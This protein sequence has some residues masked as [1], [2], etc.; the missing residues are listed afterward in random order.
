MARPVDVV[1]F[2]GG[3]AGLSAALLP[4]YEGKQV[5]LL[6]AGK[7]AGRRGRHNPSDL[8]SGLG[9]AGL[10]SDGK[11]SFFPSASALWR[12]DDR[13]A[14]HDAY[15]W[16]VRVLSD[17][18]HAPKFPSE[19]DI[20]LAGDFVGDEKTYESAYIDFQARL[21]LIERLTKN[22]AGALIRGAQ[23]LSVTETNT[24]LRVRYMRGRR[25]KSVVCKAVI[26][27]CGRFGANELATIAPWIPTVFRRVEV[28]VRVELPASHFFLQDHANLDPKYILR[29][30][31][32]VEWRTFCTCR[33]GEV[34][35]TN[36]MGLTSYSGRSDV[37][38]TRF[39]NVGFNLRLKNQPDTR[40]PLAAEI[41]H[42]LT[43]RVEPFRV[44]ID[45]FMSPGN[46]FYGSNLDELLRQ[47][48]QRLS[49]DLSDA[50]VTGPCIEGVG[51]YPA[52]D[53]NLRV[54]NL[55]PVWF[56][57]DQTG[58]FRGLTAAFVSGH[59]AARQ[60]IRHIDS[61]GG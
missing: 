15:E 5:L 11:F 30:D 50:T 56:A 29:L 7:P 27:A 59:Y 57:G 46:V 58:I 14:L 42:L 55:K 8:T 10:Y 22:S 39:S 18:T 25:P 4:L 41:E 6:E 54:C 20:H 40:S 3:P 28:G 34:V 37:A 43:G 13:D 26:M 48:L 47:G 36:F 44:G 21:K 35:E 51:F 19:L 9:G 52:V 32:G 31:D 23:V 60:A 45:A 33:N 2:G 12:L 16:F 1:I 38:A 24:G 61:T 49:A 17:F 53:N